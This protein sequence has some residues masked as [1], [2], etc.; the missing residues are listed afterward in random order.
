MK[1]RKSKKVRLK[2]EKFVSILIV[3]AIIAFPIST[4]LTKAILSETNIAVEKLKGEI[5]NQEE[6]NESLSMQ[7]DELASL[8]KIEEIATEKGLSYNNSN[9]KSIHE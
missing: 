8:D 2:G 3:L 7:V 6:V 1:K 5:K 4:V 9:I